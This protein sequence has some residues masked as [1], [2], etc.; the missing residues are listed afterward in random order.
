MKTIFV[1]FILLLVCSDVHAKILTP[2]DCARIAK[3]IDNLKPSA[4]EPVTDDKGP[5]VDVTIPPDQAV[6]NAKWRIDNPEASAAYD[7]A[8]YEEA[9]KLG[10]VFKSSKTEDGFVIDQFADGSGSS[11][12]RAAMHAV[13]QQLMGNG[14]FN[15]YYYAP[16]TT[17]PATGTT[18][19]FSRNGQAYWYRVDADMNASPCITPGQS[20]QLT[21]APY[22]SN[23]GDNT[24]FIY[25]YDSLPPNGYNRCSAQSGTMPG[26]IKRMTKVAPVAAYQDWDASQENGAKYFDTS[27]SDF[28]PKYLNQ[29]L[30]TMHSQGKLRGSASGVRD[31]AGAQAMADCARID[32]NVDAVSPPSPPGGRDYI[33]DDK[34]NVH[35][36]PQS[37]ADKFRSTNQAQ[38]ASP[39]T[40]TVRNPSGG[41][42]WRIP[43][44]VSTAGLTPGAEIISASESGNVKFYDPASGTVQETNNKQLAQVV[45]NAQGPD[46]GKSGAGGTNGFGGSGAIGNYTKDGVPL[47]GTGT[48]VLTEATGSGTGGGGGGDPEVFTPP[49]MQWPSVGSGDFS[50]SDAE[51]A[52]AQKKQD[53]TPM[54]EFVDNIYGL[55]PFSNVLNGVQVSTGGD[56]NIT[57]LSGS[58]GNIHFHK[59]VS[60]APVSGA[61]QV[62]GEILYFFCTLYALRMALTKR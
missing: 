50:T 8:I 36:V 15:P 33:I 2:S 22:A 30:Q 24:I 32:V 11:F 1:L 51:S 60:M 20:G 53:L 18:Y 37:T 54:E 62:L 28:D 23:W 42:N 57:T 48:A 43:D 58:V 40:A 21:G 5:S 34:G 14:I 29:A 35:Y 6:A 38:D 39:A 4:A 19:A 17:A 44:G 31:T 26:R 9:E 25:V 59:D 52:I 61:L 3:Y 13:M 45:R 41:G 12:N 56:S 27:R 16:S 7:A 47:N 55:F 10:V 46:G 49:T